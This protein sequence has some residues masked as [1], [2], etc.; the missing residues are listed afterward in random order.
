[1]R[2]S[3]FGIMMRKTVLLLFMTLLV[4]C[5]KAPEGDEETKP[6]IQAT[7][8]SRGKETLKACQNQ[9]VLKVLDNGID[10]ISRL[11][12]SNHIVSW[13]YDSREENHKLYTPA[14]PLKISPDGQYLL[15][16]ISFRKFQILDL[17]SSASYSRSTITINAVEEPAPEVS[18]SR[19]SKYLTLLFKPYGAGLTKQVVVYD[20]ERSEMV[21]S[22][23]EKEISFAK[24][25]YQEDSLI[26]LTFD[27]RSKYLIKTDLFTKKVIY[28]K[29]IS[30]FLKYTSMDIGA[31]EIL[32]K[33]NDIFEVYL[34]SK[35]D[36]S[37]GVEGHY[38]YD[39][40]TS[41]EYALVNYNWNELKVI[42]LFSG[43]SVLIK[44]KIK[45]I[46]LTSCELKAN[47]FRVICLD[48][49]DQGKVKIWNLEN[50]K[51]DSSCF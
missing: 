12:D 2:F 9:Q 35:G 42:E 29:R 45:E 11:R 22:L 50:D 24:I 39:I 26:S 28:K 48:S 18:F 43:T 49:V 34:E 25:N 6:Q 40:D 20:I 32:I 7:E 16:Q 36:Y 33:G 44:N 38:I 14:L 5:G 19:N 10:I 30:S 4:S 46:V 8:T 1:M 47:P 51:I 13:D 3:S 27:G 31:K 37:Y 21:L 23:T 17:A 15:R 41:G